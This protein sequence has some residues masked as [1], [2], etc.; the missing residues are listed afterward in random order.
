MTYRLAMAGRHWVV[1]SLGVLAT[2]AALGGDVERAAE[3]L[4]D[5]H[6]PKGRGSVHL[7]DTGDGVLTLIDESYNASPVSM[8]A[9]IAVLGQ[10]Q[11]AKD[12]RRI[13]VLGDMLELGAASPGLHA[14][15]AE[16]LTD[17]GVDLVFTAGAG[18][19]YLF[20]ALDPTMRGGHAQDTDSLLAM[21]MEAVEPGDVVAVKGSAGSRTGII[22]DAL[23]GLDL[24]RGERPKR[25]VNGD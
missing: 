2:V 4:A 22:V 21:V 10:T 20:E 8:R 16:V 17:E 5:L 19:A 23:A 18:M 25:A 1:N 24:S 9:A 15:L 13:A 7:I 6:A 12:G 14:A 11:P 3:A